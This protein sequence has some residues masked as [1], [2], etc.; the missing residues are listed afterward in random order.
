MSRFRHLSLVEEDLRDQIAIYERELLTP[1]DVAPKIRA[2]P[3][4]L[5]TAKNR[6]GTAQSV[7]Q[8]YAG[9]LLQTIRFRLGNDEWLQQNLDRTRELLTSLGKPG[10]AP[11]G[12]QRPVWGDVPW[13]YVAAY[14]RQ[15]RTAQ[16]AIS[17]DADTAAAYIARQAESHQELLAWTVAVRC[18]TSFDE[19]LKAWDLG[20]EGFPEVNAIN[21]SRLGTDNGS[22]GALASP[23]RKG[24]LGAGDE[25]VDLTDAQVQGATNTVDEFPT[26]GHAVRWQ[27]PRDRGLLLIFPISPFSTPG[28]NARDRVDLFEHPVARPLVVGIALSFPP[29]DTGATVEYVSGKQS[30]NSIFA[31]DDE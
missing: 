24:N 15:F 9:E 8:S 17:F 27:R 10:V 3:A 18:A 23:P 22:I 19:K 13:Q 2:H 4:M 30:S 14:L 25:A 5:V 12:D 31:S 6:M 7:R 21:R 11:R 16:D 28:K 29:S 1:R 26:M 20:I